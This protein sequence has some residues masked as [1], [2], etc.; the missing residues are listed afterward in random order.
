ME[1]QKVLSELSRFN[2]ANMEWPSKAK[3]YGTEWT[4]P[5]M[6][7]IALW[8]LGTHFGSMNKTRDKHNC[9]ANPKFLQFRNE[10]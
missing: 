5:N 3:L 2:D 1:I 8:S 4:P 6:K 10:P 7:Q 9:V